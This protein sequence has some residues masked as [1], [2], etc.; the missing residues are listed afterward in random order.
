MSRMQK[1]ALVLLSLLLLL[2]VPA[3]AL[4]LDARQGKGSLWAELWSFLASWAAPDGKSRSNI[5]PL[6]EPTPDSVPAETEC[7][8]NIDPLGCPKPGA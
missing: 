4:P 7:G 2:S 3:A 6:G 5:D 1:R 8:S